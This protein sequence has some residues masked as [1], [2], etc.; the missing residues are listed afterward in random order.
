MQP[1][2]ARRASAMQRPTPWPEESGLG[3]GHGARARA[4]R[5]LLCFSMRA[6]TRLGSQITHTHTRAEALQV[7]A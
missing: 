6:E 7:S 1:G 2:P 3:A 4:P 5:L